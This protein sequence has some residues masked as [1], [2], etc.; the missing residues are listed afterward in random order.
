MLSRSRTLTAIQTTFSPSSPRLSPGE[1]RTRALR[2]VGVAKGWHL[3][4]RSPLATSLAP[5]PQPH[6]LTTCPPRLKPATP[7]PH[8][9]SPPPHT[10]SSLRPFSNL[11][12]SYFLPH[13]APVRSALPC[14]PPQNNN[15]ASA[16]CRSVVSYQPA[17]YLFLLS[18]PVRRGVDNIQK[19]IS[20][21][22]CFCCPLPQGHLHLAL[23]IYAHRQGG[24]ARLQPTDPVNFCAHLGC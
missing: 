6:S 20:P 19:S 10:P 11:C 17:I 15:K 9:L 14:Q 22:F 7:L 18:L 12:F 13:R 5:S 16:S 21:G 3:P 4:A 1:S 24:P 23:S 8:S 2:R